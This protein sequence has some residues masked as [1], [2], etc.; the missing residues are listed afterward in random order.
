[1]WFLVTACRPACSLRKEIGVIGVADKNMARNLLFLE[2]TF[3]TQ[4]LI[5]LVKQSLINRAVRRMTDNT[6]FPYRFM[7]V[8]EWSALR[9]VT[10]KTGVVPAEKCEPA[11]M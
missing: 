11:P 4:G 2:M 3:Q 7:L 8:D 10:L 1:M 5:A 9:R 6:A